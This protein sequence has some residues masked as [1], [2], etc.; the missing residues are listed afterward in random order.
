MSLGVVYATFSRDALP[1]VRAAVG[2]ADLAGAEVAL[3][4]VRRERAELWILRADGDPLA[5]ERER[6]AWAARLGL[7]D[8]E[9]ATGAYRAVPL[10]DRGAPS[11]PATSAGAVMVVPFAPPDAA[12]RDELDRHYEQE[13]SPLLLAEPAW[14]RIRRWGLEPLAGPPWTRLAVHDLA[15]REALRSPGVAASMETAWYARLMERP[16]YATAGRPPIERVRVAEDVRHHM[17]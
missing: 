3:G 14:R 9:A 2:A 15:D 13:H 1:A 6:A 11:A 8:D 4:P 12:Q 5:P 16:W 10:S 7:G 17:C